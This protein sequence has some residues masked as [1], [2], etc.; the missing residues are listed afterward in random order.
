MTT[1]ITNDNY[2][3]PL[4]FK[5]VLSRAPIMSRN[6]Q[7][8]SLPSIILPQVLIPSPFV[9][10]PVPGDHIDYNEFNLSF[11]VDED[12]TGYLEIHDWI[13]E[14]AAPTEFS[15]STRIYDQVQ[16]GEGNDL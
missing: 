5:L 3:S 1:N 13:K 16:P 12:I 9:K 8:V 4:G 2:L 11:I 6:A 15:E 14:L 7:Q 10:I